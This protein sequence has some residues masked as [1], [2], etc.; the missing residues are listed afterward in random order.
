MANP[1]PK[2]NPN[3]ALIGKMPSPAKTPI[4]Q[5]RRN[6]K[7]FNRDYVAQYSPECLDLYDWLCANDTRRLDYLLEL[8]NLYSVLQTATFPQILDKITNRDPL[9]K[10]D[11]DSLRLIKE[12]LVDSHKLKYGDKKI[13]ENIVTVADIRKQMMSD[14]K[15]IDA[16]VLNDTIRQSPDNSGSGEDGLGQRRSDG[17]NLESSETIEAEDDN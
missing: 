9:S 16:E 11:I 15:I 8:K 7:L 6:I 1:N 17:E 3:I 2:G 4:G 13:I 14:K 10:K 12:V 5:L